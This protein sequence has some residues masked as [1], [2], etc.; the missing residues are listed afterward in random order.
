[1]LYEEIHEPVRGLRRRLRD[2][3]RVARSHHLGPLAAG[4][5]PDGGAGR[6]GRRPR[7]RP[8]SPTCASPRDELRQIE[9]AGVLHDFGKVGVRENVLIKAKKLLRGPARRI[10]LRFR[11]I[12]KALEAE[13]LE[14]KLAWRWPARGR[15][16][17]ALCAELDAELARAGWRARRDAGSSWPRPTSRRCW[18]APVLDAAGRDRPPASTSTPTASRRP[19]LEPDELAALRI[20]RGSLTDG[21]RQEI[22]SHVTHTISFLETIPWGRIAART[23]RASPAP[24]TSRW[25]AAATRAG[26]AATEIPI[27]SR[28]MTIADI[29]DALT[30]VRPPLQGGGARRRARCRHHR[31]RGQGRPLRP[32]AVQRVRRGRGLQAGALSRAGRRRWCEDGRGAARRRDPAPAVAARVRVGAARARTRPLVGHPGVHRRRRDSARSTATTA[33][34]IAPPTC[35]AFT[36]RSWRARPIR[37][38]TAS[39]SATS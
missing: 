4:R 21:E 28:M 35:S 1:M 2:R 38:A 10:E 36:C 15:R 24:T 31:Q 39:R 3:H 8:A 11:Y 9:Y 18:P 12:R 30:A 33:S 29:F 37:P 26:C 22:E 17:R 34:T 32:R 16:A 14:R 19:Y 20:E 6:A 5:H 23:C 7:R 13:A 25:T 27:E